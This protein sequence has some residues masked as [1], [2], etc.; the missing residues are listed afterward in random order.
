MLPLSI[1]EVE[2]PTALGG[3]YC[4]AYILLLL[5]VLSRHN[6][7]SVIIFLV[8]L[9]S[10]EHK[11]HSDSKWLKRNRFLFIVHL[12]LV[13]RQDFSEFP[14]ANTILLSRDNWDTAK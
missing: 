4:T 3:L 10:K 1:L 12:Q 6:G 5:N 14:K 2:I 7:C 11:E 9:S 8:D 13:Q